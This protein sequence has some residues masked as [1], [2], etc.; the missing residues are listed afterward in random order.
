MPDKFT[1]RSTDEAGNI[2]GCAFKYGVYVTNNEDR[3]KA[4]RNSSAFGKTVFEV[5]AE[6]EE[7]PAPKPVIRNPIKPKPKSKSKK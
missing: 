5:K 4:L 6:E 1:F 7:V 3:A 2:Q